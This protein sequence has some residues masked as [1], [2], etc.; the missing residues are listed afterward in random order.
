MGPRPLEDQSLSTKQIFQNSFSKHDPMFGL[1]ALDSN[2]LQFNVG[3]RHFSSVLSFVC[4]HAMLTPDS[5]QEININVF[6]TPFFK[7]AVDD[8]VNAVD[9]DDRVKVR[10]NASWSNWFVKLIVHRFNDPPLSKFVFIP[11]RFINCDEPVSLEIDDEKFQ[12]IN[13]FIFARFQNQLNSG[14]FNISDHFN[15]PWRKYTTFNNSIE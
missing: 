14:E 12:S 13:H 15:L 8:A 1:F 9:T 4:F 10:F 2:I 11:K 3:E 6:E 7:R 5:F